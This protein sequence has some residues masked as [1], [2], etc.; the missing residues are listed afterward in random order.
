MQKRRM[1][2]ALSWKNK[3]P[4]NVTPK[5]PIPVQIAYPVETGIAR[6]ARVKRVMLKIAA[7][8][9]PKLGQRRVQP[10]AYFK[11]RAITTS[12]MPAASKNHQAT[13]SPQERKTP[14]QWYQIS[15]FSFSP[16]KKHHPDCSATVFMLLPDCL[17][18]RGSVFSSRFSQSFT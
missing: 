16:N 6:S 2:D 12:N 18:R 4:T 17:L 7:T 1:G 3:I 15:N 14:T 8:M 10:S 5:A 13:E 9:P 11:Q